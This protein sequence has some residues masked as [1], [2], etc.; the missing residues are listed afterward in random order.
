MAEVYDGETLIASKFV[1]LDAGQFR[2]VVIPVTLDAGEHTLSV[3]GL[4]KTVTVE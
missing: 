3:C 4:T 1:A 2:V